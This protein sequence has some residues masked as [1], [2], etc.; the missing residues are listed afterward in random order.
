MKSQEY[1]GAS[2]V[3]DPFVPNYRKDT[4]MHATPTPA[5]VEIATRTALA[6]DLLLHAARIAGLS[7]E[8]SKD[9]G[10]MHVSPLTC[11][12][13][14]KADLAK[15]KFATPAALTEAMGLALAT[16][17]PDLVENDY[18][19]S[20]VCSL[21]AHAANLGV[22][23]LE[24]R[25]PKSRNRAYPA[26]LKAAMA[27]PEA[28]RK[29]TRRTEIADE[30]A[31]ELAAAMALN[32]RNTRL[33]ER[34]NRYAAI[35]E[36]NILP[37]GELDSP[38]ATALRKVVRD[39]AAGNAPRVD[40]GGLPLLSIAEP[41][42]DSDEA[43]VLLAIDLVRDPYRAAI[44]RSNSTESELAVG[45]ILT[46][47]ENDLIRAWVAVG[48]KVYVARAGHE[49]EAGA[50]CASHPWGRTRAT[51][52]H[53]DQQSGRIVRTVLGGDPLYTWAEKH[54][55]GIGQEP[56]RAA[57]AMFRATN[58]CPI[59]A[60]PSGP[61]IKSRSRQA[62]DAWERLRITAVMAYKAEHDRWPASDRLR[63]EDLLVDREGVLG[64]LGPRPEV[65]LSGVL[66]EVVA[67][68]QADYVARAEALWTH[69][70]GRAPVNRGE[71]RQ[72]WA[73]VKRQPGFGERPLDRFT[74]ALQVI[75]DEPLPNEI[76]CVGEAE[77]EAENE[78]AQ[79]ALDLA[80]RHQ[81]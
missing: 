33:D 50:T 66:Y 76:H 15:L 10:R 62:V 47:Q 17:H 39:L 70:G 23:G 32:A 14:A 64:K 57:R 5:T 35:A 68:L 52:N 72:K 7:V 60:L 30:Q 43:S 48:R 54:S 28:R 34:L 79:T 1:H 37:D 36:D 9:A 69:R 67:D 6:T 81:V 24:P 29:P 13:A 18:R 55:R 78:H 3:V 46:G 11:L 53:L 20:K 21:L 38:A 56:S 45:R 65:E 51:T 26:P 22:E 25:E 44:V 4:D 75:R 71:E 8:T 27:L 49:Y 58:A 31:H 61:Q 80:H 74:V 73:W 2:A 12:Q 42:P 41:L 19:Y 59:C 40:L 16:I 77:R 63:D